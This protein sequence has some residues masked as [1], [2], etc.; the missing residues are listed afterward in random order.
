MPVRVQL[1]RLL[2]II[3]FF[4]LWELGSRA[5]WLDPIF[6]GRPSAIFLDFA[7]MVINGEVFL[8]AW[9]TLEEA[10]IGF[11]LG[12]VLGMLLAFA[13]AASPF[14]A[15]V[16]DPVIFLLYGIPRIALAPLFI[17][18]FGLGIASKVVFAFV[19][20]LFLVFFNTFAGLKGV[21]RD[22]VNAVRVMGA[23]R[24]QLLLKVIF[25]AISPWVMAGLKS[26]VGMSL[27]GAIVGE[28]VGGNAGL[29]WM[30]NSAAGL[31]ETTRVFS[32]LLALGLLVLGVNQVLN[33]IEGR[34]LKWRPQNK[35]ME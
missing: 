20:V 6:F 25:P 3:A 27:L 19:L 28:Y 14:W 24:G 2:L 12:A 7:K 31:F 32:A 10:L 21:D 4:G 17:L 8:H 33:W 1:V 9:V 29:G 26:G 18:W 15:Q 22:M 11:G 23:S 35:L 5:G 13:L 34:L 16:L 30:I